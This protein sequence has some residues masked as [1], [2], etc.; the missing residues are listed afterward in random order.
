MAKKGGKSTIEKQLQVYGG[1]QKTLR[2]M[3]KDEHDK[4]AA[5]GTP[6]YE[7]Y[8]KVLAMEKEMKEVRDKEIKIFD[9]DNKPMFGNLRGLTTEQVHEIAELSKD[10]TA[11]RAVFIKELDERLEK[12]YKITLKYN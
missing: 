8:Q 4:Y 12:K 6:G 9:K 5:Y 2:G 1:I 10:Y 11:K 7:R 3:S